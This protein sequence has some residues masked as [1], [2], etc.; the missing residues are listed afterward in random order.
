GAD[1]AGATLC[2]AN[3]EHADLTGANL[4]KTDLTDARLDSAKLDGTI[5][6]CNDVRRPGCR[7]LSNNEIAV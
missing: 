2:K 6:D 1:L 5:A 7:P 4:D 3:L